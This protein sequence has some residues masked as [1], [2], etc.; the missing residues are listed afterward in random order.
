MTI[1]HGLAFV[2]RGITMNLE[3]VSSSNI[4]EEIIPF[5]TISV[6]KFLSN[7]FSVFL[8]EA[9]Q[10]SRDPPGANFSVVCFNDIV[11]SFL[12]NTKR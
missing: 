9:S 4:L 2:F 12:T 10:L 11:H 8:H 7:S 6:K 3:F 5:E 1:F